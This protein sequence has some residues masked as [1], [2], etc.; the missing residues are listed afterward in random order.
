M[1]SRRNE[2][3]IPVIIAL[4][5]VAVFWAELTQLVRAW[6]FDPFV[7]YGFLIPPISIYLIYKRREGLARNYSDLNLGVVLALVSIPVLILTR[8]YGSLSLTVFAFLPFIFGLTAAGYARRGVRRIWFP[9]AYLGFM[10]PFPPAITTPLS[11]W[12]SKLT[13]QLTRFWLDVFSV[14]YTSVYEP[15]PTISVFC[16]GEPL[17]FALDISCVSVYSLLGF[18]AFGVFFAFVLSGRLYRRALLVIVGS[19]LLVLF[20]SIRIAAILG[21]AIAFGEGI[22]V[23]LFHLLG[24]W[25]LIALSFLVVLLL[26]ERSGTAI[27]L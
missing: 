25:V 20:N 6:I 18:L 15:L 11:L 22:A 16:K 1:S 26:A 7:R 8:T 2:L 12:M 23:A 4:L 10:F 5:T 3:Y 21:L 24:G 27:N 14:R 13:F 9:I 17:K 19:L